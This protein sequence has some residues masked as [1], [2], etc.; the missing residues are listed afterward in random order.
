MITLYYLAD[1]FIDGLKSKMRAE[2]GQ[3]AVEYALVLALVAIV[4]AFALNAGLADALGSLV[5]KISNLLTN[6]SV[7][8]A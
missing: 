6:T 2:E 3:T 7:Q 8:T 4:L 5:D 1:S